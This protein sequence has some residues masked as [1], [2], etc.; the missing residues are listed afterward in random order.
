[1]INST[2]IRQ[3]LDSKDVD[4]VHRWWC[5]LVETFLYRRQGSMDELPKTKPRRGKV[6][7]T[8]MQNMAAKWC[9][10]AATAC[11]KAYTPLQQTV[12]RCMDLKARIKRLVSRQHGAYDE[13]LHSEVLVSL[14]E[15]FRHGT[16]SLDHLK[17]D[18]LHST[19][20]ALDFIN[21]H[22][23]LLDAVPS[24]VE[25]DTDRKDCKPWQD[26]V[27]PAART[28]TQ[29]TFNVRTLEQII[30]AADRRMA[31]IGHA[32]RKAS[33][34]AWHRRNDINSNEARR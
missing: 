27:A 2:T 3:S 7:P 26:D 12:G 18:D 34:E 15:V 23:H 30:M 33:T 13:L 4:G 21:E 25:S 24:C 9:G 1:M 16:T 6:M 17:K 32:M 31:W 19:R 14:D 5:L 28:I 29:C 8:H 22:L 11:S 10:P 20:M